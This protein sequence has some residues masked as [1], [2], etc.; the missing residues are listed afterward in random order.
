VPDAE[1]SKISRFFYY[2]EVQISLRL[3]HSLLASI[4]PAMPFDLHESG[5]QGNAS[6]NELPLMV[7]KFENRN[8]RHPKIE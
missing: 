7:Q 8:N 5:P 4:S 6:A 3:G 1:F 2:I